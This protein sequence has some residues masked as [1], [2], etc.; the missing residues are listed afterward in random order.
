MRGIFLSH[1]LTVRRTILS[2]GASRKEQCSFSLNGY[3]KDVA[4]SDI[5]V[6]ANM[7]ERQGVLI[8]TL[9]CTD[10]TVR[11]RTLNLAGPLALSLVERLL[12]LPVPISVSISL[13]D[14]IQT[15]D[16]NYQL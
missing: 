6:A 12:Q 14:L 2:L 16:L 11:K 5:Y 4:S 10:S 3:V 1:L 8:T 13:S 9:Y 15:G 7:A